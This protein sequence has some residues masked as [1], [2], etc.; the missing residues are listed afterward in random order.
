M[1]SGIR[2]CQDGLPAWASQRLSRKTNGWRHRRLHPCFIQ[3]LGN[4]H[5]TFLIFKGLQELEHITANTE[6][7]SMSIKDCYLQSYCIFTPLANCGTAKKKKKK[8]SG[9]Q[10]FT[11]WRTILIIFD[12][13]SHYKNWNHKGI[14]FASRMAP[15]AHWAWPGT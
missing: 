12:R 11:L 7:R 9:P 15:C 5:P 13:S 14:T 3:P 1:L 6:M 8:S 4:T 10:Y 2:Q